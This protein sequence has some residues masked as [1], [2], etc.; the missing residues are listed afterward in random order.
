MADQPSPEGKSRGGSILKIIMWA[1]ILL[2]A[3]FG[4][5]AKYP[6]SD[7]HVAIQK[8]EGAEHSLTA[9]ATGEHGAETAVTVVEDTEGRGKAD[10]AEG[11]EPADEAQRVAAAEP[12]GQDPVSQ[13]ETATQPVATMVAEVL[14]T[15]QPVDP[16]PQTVSAAPEQEES[17][18]EAVQTVETEVADT[19]APAREQEKEI[20][21]EGAA[22]NEVAE[23]QAEVAG[24]RGGGSRDAG[25]RSGGPKR[26]RQS[27]H[28]G[29][30]IL[31]A[32]DGTSRRQA[33]ACGCG[34]HTNSQHGATARHRTHSRRI[35][36]IRAHHRTDCGG[37]RPRRGIDGRENAARDGQQRRYGNERTPR[38][39]RRCARQ[40]HDR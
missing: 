25:G 12:A 7:D 30:D 32:S 11:S 29:R 15:D 2:T 37:T 38:D 14:Q 9:P 40:R 31:D 20:S 13:T 27:S 8:E 5:N 4:L 21:A 34:A 26:K 33:G 10:K 35:R 36:Q 23:T 24:T 1:G 17:G 18:A 6:S 16:T 39:R 19:T 3:W 28:S 22:P